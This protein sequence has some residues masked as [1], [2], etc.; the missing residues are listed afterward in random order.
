MNYG[1]LV[2]VVKTGE[3]YT[4]EL[5]ESLSS[6]IGKDICAFANSSGGR[7]IIG[8]D[9][10]TSDI[11]GYK[12]TNANRSKIQDIA[13]NM[14]P[15]FNV[16]VEQVKDLVVIYVPEGKDKPYT[17]N[18]HFYLRYGANSQQLNRDE[19]RELFQKENLISFERNTVD[20]KDQDFSEDAFAGFRKEAGLD[21]DLS[22][23]HILGNLNLLTNGRL[24]NCGVL[25]FSKDIKFYFPN[26]TVACFLYADKEQ[27][28]IIDS[29]EFSGDFVSNLNEAYN[30]LLS[31]LN[32][33]I[34]IDD[35]KHTTKL[36]LPKEGLREAIIN[37]MIHRDYLYSSNIQIHISPERVEIVNPG[38]LL[39]P[40]EDLGKRSAQ[41]NPLLTDMVHR[42]GLVE[43]AGSGI[44][45]M[46]KSM[47]EY[48]LGIDFEIGSFFSAVFHRDIRSKSEANP[49][50]IRSKSEEDRSEWILAYVR[51][52]KKI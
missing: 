32:T 3:G 35:L 20:F 23:E 39:F 43:K 21:G 17:I 1:E 24:N 9:D 44:K 46:R 38:K 36:E 25:L 37:A 10:K 34:I 40:E 31:K 19:I 27:T 6:T 51:E 22:K 50:Q 15:A 41:R 2:D 52:N 11:K 12:L 28:E 30:Y 16:R 42:L 4:I 47:K 8:V 33:A 26:A 7:I 18:G 13:R 45:R 29:K 14:S 5:K 49:K 48:N